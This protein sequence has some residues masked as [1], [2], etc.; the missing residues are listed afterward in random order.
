MN[1]SGF[2][3]LQFFGVVLVIGI[4]LAVVYKDTVPLGAD[5]PLNRAL[6]QDVQKQ[7]QHLGAPAPAARAVPASGA[8]K[9]I[10]TVN[11]PQKVY[12]GI[13]DNGDYK[14]YIL[15]NK[16]H[17]FMVTFTGCPYARAFR[18]QLERLFSYGD[19]SDYYDKD[20]IPVGQGVAVSCNASHMNCPKAWLFD[21][22]GE[23]ICI[24][25]PVTRQA[26]IDNSQNPRQIEALLDQYKDW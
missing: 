1:R 10:K 15:G 19:Y 7:A 14:E 8:L 12:D 2:T 4:I 9:N 5:G 22:C 16:K 23:G 21:K 17:V 18:Q 20:I 11:I 13:K 26:V 6:L 25:N 24:I 3:V